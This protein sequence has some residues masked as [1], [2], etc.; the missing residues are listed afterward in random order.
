MVL[1]DT[2]VWIEHFRRGHQAFA[3]LL[4]DGLIMVHPFVCGELACGNLKSRATALSDILALPSATLATNAEVL[5][6]VQDRKLW[7]QGLGGIDVHLLA[8]ALISNCRLWALDRR[9]AQVA[10]ELGLT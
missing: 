4:A 5:A 8:S 2:S 9:L 7:G 6:F 10:D 1:A 3:E